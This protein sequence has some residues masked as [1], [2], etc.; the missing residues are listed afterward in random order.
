MNV[1]FLSIIHKKIGELHE[2]VQVHSLR[3]VDYQTTPNKIGQ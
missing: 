2:S 3:H 1:S